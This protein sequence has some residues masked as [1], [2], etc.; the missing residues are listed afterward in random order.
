MVINEVRVF[1]FAAYLF[2]FKMV[3]F[4]PSGIGSPSDAKHFSV[5]PLS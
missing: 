4:F 3:A 1:L 2:G 5:D